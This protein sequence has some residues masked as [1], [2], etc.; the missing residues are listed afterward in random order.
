MKTLYE[1]ENLK[2]SWEHNWL[3]SQQLNC[4]ELRMENGFS[5]LVGVGTVGASLEVL[6]YDADLET[7][8]AK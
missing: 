5:L 4:W 1:Q 8:S 6:Q 2:L 3:H 7:Q